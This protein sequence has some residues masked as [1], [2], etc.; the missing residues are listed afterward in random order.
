MTI[1][2]LVLGIMLVATA[3]GL[4]Q[5][6]PERIGVYDSRAVA[7]AY[8]GSDI[9]IAIVQEG[10]AKFEAAKTAGDEELAAALNEEGRA[11]QQLMHKQGFSTAPI[12]D[13]LEHIKDNIPGIM[14]KHA[15]GA[16]VSKWDE[17]TLAKFAGA[18]R[19]DVTMDLVDAFNPNERQRGYAVDIQEKEPIPL[20]ELEH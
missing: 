9:F 10:R 7:V 13:I 3:A 6:E 17:A 5:A 1:R 2:K 11:L 12:D 18:E 8:A 20:E 19:V 14:E 4:A 15:V 16:L